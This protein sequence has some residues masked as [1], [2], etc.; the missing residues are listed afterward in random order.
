MTA[1]Q[2]NGGIALLTRREREVARL[3]SRGFTNRDIA[4]ELG[5]AAGTAALH[6]EHVRGKL[7]FRSR[8]QVAVW[9]AQAMP[10]ST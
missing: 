10:T 5:I 7:G 3:V 2:V 9:I 8:T 1:R 6:V 4:S